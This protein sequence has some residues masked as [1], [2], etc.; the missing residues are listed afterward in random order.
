MHN[1]EEFLIE[2]KIEDGDLTP[3]LKVEKA[4]GL[5]FYRHYNLQENALSK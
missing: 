5:T 1:L 3:L 2:D 4:D